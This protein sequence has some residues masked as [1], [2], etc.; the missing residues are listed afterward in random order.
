MLANFTDQTL[1]RS[2]PDPTIGRPSS[3]ILFF[4]Y[5]LQIKTYR[6]LYD[7]RFKQETGTKRRHITLAAFKNSSCDP[8]RD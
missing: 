4:F 3:S 2:T 5:F 7:K 1:V 6:G 8:L